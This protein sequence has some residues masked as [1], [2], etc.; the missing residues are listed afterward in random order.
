MA[1]LL[2]LG[3]NDDPHVA[4]VAELISRSEEVGVHILDYNDETSFSI[5]LDQ[6]GKAKITINGKEVTNY[7]V[8]DRRKIIP[9]TNFYIKGDDEHSGYVA[10]EWRSLYTLICGISE[11]KVL[12]SLSSRTCLIK[13]YQQ[14]VAMKSGF[15]TPPTIV[16]NDKRDATQFQDDHNLV[17]MKSLSGA[18]IQTA[19]EGE[20]VP[21]NVMTM[22]I[23][24]VDLHDA[25]SAEIAYCPHFFQKEIVKKYELRVVH[26]DGEIWPFKV[27]SQNYKTTEVDWRKGTDVV[28][29]SFF[30]IDPRLERMINDF[31]SSMEMTFGSLDLIIDHSD[32]CWFL[33]CNQDGAWGW[34]DDIVDG[35]ASQSFAN[36]LPRRMGLSDHM[37][38]LQ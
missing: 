3:T 36:A 26:V 32:S 9:G 10:Q 17:I 12:N 14:M 2:I 22:R 5:S 37:G 1:A 23:D 30:P 34:L 4:R 13:P 15:L 31:M 27:D 20:Y 19:G 7:I 16:T 8:W 18:K 21:F 35:A 24:P 25:S 29:F 33:E 28:G 6:A 38:P 11:G